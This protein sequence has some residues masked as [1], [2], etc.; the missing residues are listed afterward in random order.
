M[1]FKSFFT[2]FIMTIF[3]VTILPYISFA[4]QFITVENDLGK[5]VKSMISIS[6]GDSNEK[7]WVTDDK[8]KL[9]L[10]SPCRKGNQIKAFPFNRLYY[11][12]SVDCSPKN[13]H[14]IVKVTKKCYV[15]NLRW[16]A[17]V[18]ED[19]G[20][21][22]N[23]AL[24]YLELAAR[25]H[26]IDPFEASE[27]RE[28]TYMNFS[29]AID[30]PENIQVVHYDLL[31]KRKV[32]TKEFVEYLKT[33]QK[34]QGLRETGVIDFNTISTESNINVMKMLEQKIEH[35]KECSENND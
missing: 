25:Y 3:C 18:F 5:G 27:F 9:I 6:L 29:V 19:N 10:K 16:N 17:K 31:Q 22:G 15:V 14:L 13:S 34:K 11:E 33:Y 1:H 28:K 8:G 20:N 23:A 7:K 32:L 21:S 2:A 30:T 26:S 35:P 12:G 24:A 4:K